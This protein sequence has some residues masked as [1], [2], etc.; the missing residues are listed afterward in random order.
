ML[1]YH[2]RSLMAI[3]AVSQCLFLGLPSSVKAA[4]WIFRD[5]KLPSYPERELTQVWPDKHDYKL[6]HVSDS[7]FWGAGVA[8]W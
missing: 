8:Q 2:L 5:L 3:S 1:V 6:D 7:H 4:I